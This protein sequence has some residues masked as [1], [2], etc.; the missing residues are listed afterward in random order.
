MQNMVDI[1]GIPKFL[2]LA[3]LVLTFLFGTGTTMAFMALISKASRY[4]GYGCV[5]FLSDNIT[6]VGGLLILILP[7]IFF[8]KEFIRDL[9]ISFFLN[10]ISVS[11][12]GFHIKQ[13]EDLLYE[14]KNIKAIN[15]KHEAWRGHSIVIFFDDGKNIEIPIINKTKEKTIDFLKEVYCKSPK[16]IKTNRLSEKWLKE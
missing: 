7:C 2:G 8:F 9:K 1:L 14:W 4:T 12:D 6:F 10:T 5:S 13:K 3:S 15:G 16:Q 11:E